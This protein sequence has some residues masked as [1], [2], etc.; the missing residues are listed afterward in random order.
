MRSLFLL[1]HAMNWR[2]WAAFATVGIF[3][4]SA[5]ILTPMLPLPELLA[6]AVRF[7]I[8]AVLLALVALTLRRRR[9]TR[10]QAFP[11]VPSMV[12]G[13]T[14]VG[15]PYAL[16]V[17]A[18]DS[19]SSGLVAVL[20][21]AMPLAALFFG[22]KADSAS[23][24]AMAIGMGGVAFLVDQGI[25]YSTA[26]VEGALLL[27]VG[28][29]LGAL[30]L[31][32]AK[33]RIKRENFLLSSAIQCA[34]AFV[35]LIFLSGIGGG[36]RATSWNRSSILVLMI[37]S[38]AEGAIALP[39]LLWLL[40]RIEPW[41]AASLQW[42]ATLVAVAEAAWFLRATPTLEMIAGAMLIGGAI[43]WLMLSRSG[44][45]TVTLRITD[46]LQSR[47]DASDSNQG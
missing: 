16:A 29:I 39:L 40:S 4:G 35:L 42:A 10:R 7:A 3:W 9:T 44:S 45:G 38:V 28:V 25:T 34:V 5:W 12:L 1:G 33:L 30:S 6:G 26:Q 31:N 41:Q 19:V 43:L 27:A 23:I 11:L 47:L 22:R 8:A 17:W 32:Y 20:Y 18:K 2:T 13:I 37:L 14:M 21:S 46:C 36:L 24:P 15:M